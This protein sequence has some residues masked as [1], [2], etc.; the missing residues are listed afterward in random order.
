MK[1]REDLTAQDIAQLGSSSGSPAPIPWIAN[2][3][4][5]EHIV[6]GLPREAREPDAAPRSE[7]TSLYPVCQQEQALGDSS[8]HRRSR[9]LR[10]RFLEAHTRDPTTERG[11]ISGILCVRRR[12]WSRLPPYPP[13]TPSFRE[14]FAARYLRPGLSRFC[15]RAHGEVCPSHRKACQ[16]EKKMEFSC[17][18]YP[19]PSE[20]AARSCSC[21]NAA[22]VQ[23]YGPSQLSAIRPDDGPF[24]NWSLRRLR[25]GLRI[26]TPAAPGTSTV[27]RTGPGSRHSPHRDFSD[28]KG[29]R[30]RQARG[31]RPPETLAARLDLLNRSAIEH[32]A[33][34][35]RSSDRRYRE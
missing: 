16:L 21:P 2:P 23:A 17:G 30:C 26:A 33:L 28:I 20:S 11:P 1:V 8:N 19:S 25:Y 5:V 31:D 35:E 14:Y 24:I 9:R 3:P 12:Q 27:T 15:Q 32:L 10:G 4:R 22:G 18:T 6:R 7:K 13:W 34:I 29:Q